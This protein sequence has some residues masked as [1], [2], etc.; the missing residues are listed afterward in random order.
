MVVDMGLALM[1]A[2]ALHPAQAEAL[3]A[4][5]AVLPAEAVVRA[6]PAAEAVEE[7]GKL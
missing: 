1:V 2:E 5:V 6:H 3:M 4:E 7:E